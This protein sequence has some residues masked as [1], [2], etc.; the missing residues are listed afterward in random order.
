M[1]CLL[2]THVRTL[3]PLAA[4]TCWSIESEQTGLKEVRS[5]QSRQLLTSRAFHSTELLWPL[6][7]VWNLVFILFWQRQQHLELFEYPFFQLHLN[8]FLTQGRPGVCQP[9]LQPLSC[10]SLPSPQLSA[11]EGPTLIQPSCV[12][13]LRMLEKKK[14]CEK[15]WRDK[16]GKI[17]DRGR[18]SETGLSGARGLGGKGAMWKGYKI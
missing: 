4:G 6:R 2:P 18:V 11:H 3:C 10:A 15:V 17:T 12:I 7:A 16:K 1:S 5:W 8:V 9:L 14:N 13:L